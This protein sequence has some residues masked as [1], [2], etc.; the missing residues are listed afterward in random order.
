DS[1]TGFVPGSSIESNLNFQLRSTLRD[2][3]TPL[4]NADLDDT[5]QN[6]S[7]AAG[8]I[9]DTGSSADASAASATPCPIVDLRA[10]DPGTGP[11]TGDLPLY[12]QFRTV[13]GSN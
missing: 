7:S 12:K 11:G 13:G 9:G 10:T 3:S 6:C 1:A 8:W 5:L 2:T 4:P